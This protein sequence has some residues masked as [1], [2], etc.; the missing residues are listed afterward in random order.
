MMPRTPR[1]P[2]S[3]KRPVNTP[4]SRI[5]AGGEGWGGPAKG[6]S[7]SRL[8]E[9]GDPESDAVRALSRDPEHLAFKEA[10]QANMLAVQIEIARAGEAEANR[11]NAADKVLDRLGGKPKQQTDITSAGE[12]IGY[13]I[14]APA[15]APD[16]DAWAAQH[17]PH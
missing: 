5:P 4:A 6:A 1:N 12:R 11:L 14:E 9:A 13:V 7:V 16:A 10:L 8:R 2:G 17:R 15:E 3:G